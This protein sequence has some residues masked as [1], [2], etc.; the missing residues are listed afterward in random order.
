M[1]SIERCLQHFYKMLHPQGFFLDMG[2]V[3]E[4]HRSSIK[5]TFS[6]TSVIKYIV[7]V[8]ALRK[9]DSS[10]EMY[11]VQYR[12]HHWLV[13]LSEITMNTCIGR[14]IGWFMSNLR[15]KHPCFFLSLAFTCTF[16][17]KIDIASSYPISFLTSFNI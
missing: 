4:S 6:H 9:N 8:F 10:N 16:M 2:L 12:V 7:N 11:I 14:E 17:Y 5:S 3:L 13:Q 1:W 15:A